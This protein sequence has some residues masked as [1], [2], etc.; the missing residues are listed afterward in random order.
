MTLILE[1]ATDGGGGCGLEGVG[2][3]AIGAGISVVFFCSLA[4]EIPK[5]HL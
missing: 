2:E 5:T 4:A 3:Y 1:R